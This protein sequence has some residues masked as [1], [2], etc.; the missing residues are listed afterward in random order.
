VNCVGFHEKKRKE[1]RGKEG[2]RKSQ[3]SRQP[4]LS[5]GNCRPYYRER[6][7]EKF[8]WEILD[9]RG[10]EKV[11]KTKKV[12]QKKDVFRLGEKDGTLGERHYHW[13][14][15]QFLGSGRKEGV[16]LSCG[17]TGDGVARYPTTALHN[18]EETGVSILTIL[19]FFGGAGHGG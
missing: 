18:T 15:I 10:K 19:K 6:E 7:L 14:S 8:I 3:D 5:R 17:L 16:V 9:L 2:E 13:S 11:R 1:R 4:P 12:K